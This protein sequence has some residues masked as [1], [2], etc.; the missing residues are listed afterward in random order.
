MLQRRE[1]FMTRRRVYEKIRDQ[2]FRRFPE[3][4]FRGSAEI[5]FRGTLRKQRCGILAFSLKAN[6]CSQRLE[7]FNLFPLL[8]NNFVALSGIC[9]K[10]S[11]TWSR[12]KF[13]PDWSARR[14]IRYFQRRK[15]RPA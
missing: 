15:S 6:L 12:S 2:C 11:A 9:F 14:S 7:I 1:L 5:R 10:Y 4:G 3:F 8:L 13:A